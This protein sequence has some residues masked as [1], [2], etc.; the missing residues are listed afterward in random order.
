MSDVIAGE[1]S[2]GVFVKPVENDRICL[3]AENGRRSFSER[4]KKKLRPVRLT[5][6]DETGRR[7]GA[8]KYLKDRRNQT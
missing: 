7:Q 5:I 3:G 4:Q 2:M 8:F 6:N 1:L